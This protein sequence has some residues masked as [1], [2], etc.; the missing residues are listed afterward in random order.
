MKVPPLRG[1]W[2]VAQIHVPLSSLF[3][4]EDEEPASVLREESSPPPPPLPLPQ[5]NIELILIQP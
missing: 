5:R 1:I 4:T 2:R 3:I